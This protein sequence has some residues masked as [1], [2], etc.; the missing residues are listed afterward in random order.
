MESAKTS[1]N[2]NG[3]GDGPLKHI[4][5]TGGA[6]FL[7]SF[8]CERLLADGH[9]VTCLDNF[10]T[11]FR[12]NIET[13]LANPRFR[14]LDR[15]V[16]DPLDASFDEIYNFACPASP[17]HYQIDPVFTFK[18]CIL[19]ALNMLEL[20]RRSNA[21]I[22]Q[23]STSEVYGDPLVHPQKEDYLGNVNT[24]GVRSCYDEGKRG[25]ETLFA[26]FRR[27]HGVNIRVA[28][29]FNTYGPGMSPNDGRVVSNFIMQALRGEDL[30]I[31]GDGSQTR[32]FCFRDDLV[33]GI[34]ALM[35]AP[36]ALT[37]PVNIGNPVEFTVGDL[38]KMVTSK[39][40]SRS[41]I[42]YLPRPED[43]PLQRCPDISRARTELHWEPKV[44]LDEGLDHTIAYFSSLLHADSRDLVSHD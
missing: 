37:S 35:A 33:D 44:A 27:M 36:D 3:A 9:A 12:G 20:A 14:L 43:D 25:A 31:Y 13:L 22:I 7:G 10:R 38:A 5:I 15:C 19:G 29:I 6:G 17:I 34:L 41:R 11:G 39:I 23:A 8:L 24:S 40:K 28:R 32:S 4:L 16:T 18:T 21:K 30:T 42:V 2:L 1:P 26:D